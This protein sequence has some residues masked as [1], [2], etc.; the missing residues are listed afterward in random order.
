M[1][2]ARACVPPPPSV[3]HLRL[4]PA[5]GV[6]LLARDEVNKQD[7]VFLVVGVNLRLRARQLGEL[8]LV[9]LEHVAE[10]GRQLAVV[11]RDDHESALAPPELPGRTRAFVHGSNKRL[12]P[13]V[14][15]P[16]FPVA[17]RV[18]VRIRRVQ[19]LLVH[20]LPRSLDLSLLGL[21]R[22]EL[23][24]D[25]RSLVRVR[26]E[27]GVAG[28]LELLCVGD[29][30]PQ[31]RGVRVARRPRVAQQELRLEVRHVCV[32]CPVALELPRDACGLAFHALELVL[33]HRVRVAEEE[34]EIRLVLVV[35]HAL[36][37][38]LENVRLRRGEVLLLCRHVVVRDRAGLDARVVPP[39]V[40]P[41]L[42]RA[43]RLA[44]LGLPGVDL[45]L[46]L[47]GGVLLLLA[48]GVVQV[49][50]DRA[51]DHVGLRIVANQPGEDRPGGLERLQPDAHH[52]LGPAGGIQAAADELRLDVV[53]P[54]GHRALAEVLHLVRLLREQLHGSDDVRRAGNLA[55]GLLQPAR[56]EDHR[57]LVLGKGVR[58]R[59]Q[60]AGR[61]R[62]RTVLR[63]LR[64]WGNAWSRAAALHEVRRWRRNFLGH[65]I[66]KTVHDRP[67]RRWR[68]RRRGGG[69]RSGR[70]SGRRSGGSGGSAGEGPLSR[71]GGSLIAVFGR[72][73]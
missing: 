41:L 71:A 27:P 16:H 9:R 3:Q 4:L 21:E 50:L 66:L 46:R 69:G 35:L 12:H 38:L 64:L 25:P 63:Q 2:S 36:A 65:V 51:D 68:P 19:R 8:A 1:C 57:H 28:G 32:L 47:G 29:L 14:P 10:G 23:Q 15:M 26:L 11:G 56:A 61:P 18:T 7:V 5:P 54:V 58:V 17:A 70:R 53:E 67:A 33:A 48:L 62:D 42:V 59:P 44:V 45:L 37:H 40:A 13:P 20:P 30:L 6:A 34:A 49:V 31:A 55:H 22:A 39:L 52:G 24:D 72:A 43:H 73:L 60:Q